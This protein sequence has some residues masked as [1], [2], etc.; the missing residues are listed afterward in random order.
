MKRC[1]RLIDLITVATLLAA[2]GGQSTGMAVTR[3]PLPA[4]ITEQSGEATTV[5]TPEPA[6]GGTWVIAVDFEPDTLDVHRTG[7]SVLELIM[8]LVGGSVLALDPLTDEFIPYLAESYSLSDDGL[9]WEIRFRQ[10]LKWHDG[11]PFTAHDYVWTMERILASPSPATGAMTDGMAWAEAVDDRTMRIHMDHPNSSMVFGLTSAYLQPLP[12]AY[13][14]RVGEEAYGRNP[15]GLGPYRF[16]EWR[17]G[18]RVILERNPDFNWGPA[19]AH[20]GPA[21]IEFV[22]FRVIPEYSTR[23]AGIESGEIDAALLMNKDVGRVEGLSDFDVI[24]MHFQG[25]GPYLLFNVSVPPFD[26]I[27]VRKAFNLAINREELIRVVALGYG[28][29]LWGPIT[30]ATFGYWEGAEDIG[31]GYNLDAARA[32]M[33]EAG[34]HLNGD[35]ILESDGQPL[36]LVFKVTPSLRGD[37]IK[38]AE[39]L[40]EQFKDLGVKLEIEQVEGGV[41]QAAIA[42]GDYTL[43]ISSWGWAEAQIIAPLFLSSMIGGM[44]ESHIFDPELDPLLLA[45]LAEPNREVLQ[46]RLDAAQRYLIEKAYTAPLFTIQLHLALSR[47]ATE[48]MVRPATEDIE[49]FDAYIESSP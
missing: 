2:C 5:R 44:N 18:E 30:P 38:I 46:D 24:P 13:I 40:S 19:Y 11:T 36:E 42:A 20:P 21:Y 8:K 16:R 41:R 12:K 15:M 14:E 49:L 39:V 32:L 23:L 4:L 43:S 31:Y 1:F 33:A 28:K 25:A 37:S 26:D 9:L 7:S 29:P 35:G 27:R 22:E 34:Y 47:R 48:V 6:V 17:T 45:V 10:G 3:E